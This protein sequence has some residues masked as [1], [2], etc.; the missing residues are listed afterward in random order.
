MSKRSTRNLIAAAAFGAGT[1]LIYGTPAQA[2][3]MPVKRTEMHVTRS[4][5]IKNAWV[6]HHRGSHTLTHIRS[7]KR[8]IR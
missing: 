3:S 6:R 5:V 4:T 8:K 2:Q 7:L 1:A